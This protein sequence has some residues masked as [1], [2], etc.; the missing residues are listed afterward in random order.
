MTTRPARTRARPLI[1]PAAGT[2][3]E[4]A[5]NFRLIY[6][7]SL[8]DHRT[9]EAA[10]GVYAVRVV[11]PLEVTD[12]GIGFNW[13]DPRVFQVISDMVLNSAASG[14]VKVD[15]GDVPDYLE[16]QLVDYS[17]STD[18]YAGVDILKPAANAPLQA[19]VTKTDILVN[20]TAEFDLLRWNNSTK[21]WALL[22]FGSIKRQYLAHK[23]DDTLGWDYARYS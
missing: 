4:F 3:R 8:A 9:I 15:A 11:G 14:L 22:P 1:N 12:N 17:G 19:R 10:G 5:E 2:P 18:D 16:N 7:G 23:E 13:Q 20:G 6:A 21:K